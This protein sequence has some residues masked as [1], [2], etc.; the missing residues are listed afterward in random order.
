MTTIVTFVPLTPA[1]IEWY[2]ATGE[3]FDKAGAYAIQG[4]GGVFVEAIRGSVSNV[5]GLPLATVAAARLGTGGPRAGWRSPDGAVS[6]LGVRLLT[7]APV[8]TIGTRID[9]VLTA[10]VRVRTRHTP[11]EACTT[12]P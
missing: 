1:S 12:C 7:R 2:L 4:A 11:M 5:V 3:P 8:P 9:R 6:T 10:S